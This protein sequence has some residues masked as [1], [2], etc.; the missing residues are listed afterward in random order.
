M[1]ENEVNKQIPEASKEVIEKS[2]D[3]ELSQIVMS[4]EDKYPFLSR[5]PKFK[6]IG[7]EEKSGVPIYMKT[8]YDSSKYTCEK[9]RQLRKERG[10][11]KPKKVIKNAE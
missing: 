6:L 9:L 3:K 7:F 1:L 8:W 10:V 11:S 5:L 2:N 4:L